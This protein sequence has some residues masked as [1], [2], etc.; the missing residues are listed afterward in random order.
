MTK[1]ELHRDIGDTRHEWNDDVR[2]KIELEWKTRWSNNNV[3]DDF[4]T[5]TDV[6]EI[7]ISYIDISLV[8]DSILGHYSLPRPS[9]KGKREQGP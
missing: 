3:D 7:D 1:S 2:T 9:S 5:D 8:C 6:D 4:L